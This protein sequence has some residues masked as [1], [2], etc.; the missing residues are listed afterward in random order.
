VIFVFETRS[1]Q[2]FVLC[3]NSRHSCVWHHTSQRT[4]LCKWCRV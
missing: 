4:S 1:M 3:A 2:C